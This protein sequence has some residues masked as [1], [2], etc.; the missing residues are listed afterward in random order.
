MLNRLGI[1]AIFALLAALLIALPMGFALSRAA[2]AR[3]NDAGMK[4]ED[5]RPIHSQ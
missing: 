2:K 4:T 5:P 3:G 1:T